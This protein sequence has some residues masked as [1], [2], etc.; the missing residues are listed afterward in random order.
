MS[1]LKLAVPDRLEVPSVEPREQ[2]ALGR[3]RT[4]LRTWRRDRALR[5]HTRAIIVV[6]RIAQRRQQ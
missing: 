2:Q 1:D 4:Q 6:E 5:F 3:L